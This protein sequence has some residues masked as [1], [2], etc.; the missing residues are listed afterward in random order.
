[1][2]PPWIVRLVILVGFGCVV[3]TTSPQPVRP[4]PSVDVDAERS[5]TSENTLPHDQQ[6]IIDIQLVVVASSGWRIEGCK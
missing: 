3:Q 1:M 4:G 2:S 6:S 5:R